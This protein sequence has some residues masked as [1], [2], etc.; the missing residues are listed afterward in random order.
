MESSS[1]KVLV[2]VGSVLLG[3]PA[4][5]AGRICS[6]GGSGGEGITGDLVLLS[7]SL[8]HL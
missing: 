6:G 3:I 5:L 2:V 8:L 4:R 1:P 7:A